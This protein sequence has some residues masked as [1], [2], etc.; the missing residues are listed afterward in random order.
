[1]QVAIHPPWTEA[2]LGLLERVGR[3]VAF[4]GAVVRGF[5][6]ACRQPGN[7][8]VQCYHVGVGSLPLVI[9]AACSIG[10]VSWLQTRSLLADYGSETLLPGF[11]AIFVLVGLGPVLTALVLAGQVGARLGAELGSMRITEQVD[12][13]EAMGLSPVRHLASVRVMACV[14]MLPLLTVSLDVVALGASYGSEALGGTLSAR[15]YAHESLRF[16]TLSN[17]VPATLSSLLFGLL[18]GTTGCWCGLSAGSG[19][20]EVGRASTH[21]VIGS[22]LLVL[23]TNVFWVRLTDLLFD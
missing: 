15:Q 10:V 5:G 7:L 1:M 4:T 17:V 9:A 16:L 18:I 11:V 3:Y 23:L 13:L 8:L 19:T 22:M 12:A 20:E 2:V 6:T 21:G 14:L